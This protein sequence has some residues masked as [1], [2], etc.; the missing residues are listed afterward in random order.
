MKEEGKRLGKKC[1]ILHFFTVRSSLFSITNFR[2]IN[3][4]LKLKPLVD[5]SKDDVDHYTTEF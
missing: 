2:S 5:C 1:K 3:D 4:V